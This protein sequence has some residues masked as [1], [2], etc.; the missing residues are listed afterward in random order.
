MHNAIDTIKDIVG[1]DQL[2]IVDVISESVT[3][4][5]PGL[6]EILT[7]IKIKKLGKRL[8]L[9]ET[10]LNQIKVR[11][12]KETNLE[13]VEQIKDFVLPIFLQKLMEEDEDQ[14]IK[15]LVKSINR[16]IDEKSLNE[17]HLVLI[18]DILDNLRCMEIDFLISLIDNIPF[19]ENKNIS[20]NIIKFIE[21]KLEKMGLIEMANSV[22]LVPAPEMKTVSMAYSN[23]TAIT[24]LGKE[25]INFIR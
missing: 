16:T 19:L 23:E 6:G 7:N 22:K 11:I 18:F 17:S 5:I 8:T 25:F 24:E 2:E 10:E 1:L 3:D 21:T 4:M 15:Y 9:V 12:S 20:Q 13:K 14:K